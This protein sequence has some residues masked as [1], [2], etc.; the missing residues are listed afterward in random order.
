MFSDCHHVTC[1]WRVPVIGGSSLVLLSVR[2]WVELPLIC[3][4]HFRFLF[5][6]R[7]CI[8]AQN[9]PVIVRRAACD[10]TVISPLISVFLGRLCLLH[11]SSSVWQRK[12]SSIFSSHVTRR[13][14]PSPF[15]YF[16]SKF[17]QCIC[18]LLSSHVHILVVSFLK[19]H[20]YSDCRSLRAEVC[21]WEHFNIQS[22][23]RRC[24]AGQK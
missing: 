19:P 9:A 14:S 7:C 15:A 3:S 4:W 5:L 17:W 2:C 23:W 6:G 24:A 21:F 18:L 11:N 22:E 8:C 20:H 13:H 16:F 12:R 1:V 10:I